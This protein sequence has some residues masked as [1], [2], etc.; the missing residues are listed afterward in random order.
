MARKVFSSKSSR[1]II[2][3][4]LLMV[5]L[6]FC[7]SHGDGIRKAFHDA[8]QRNV[9]L[10][11]RDLINYKVPS[12]DYSGLVSASSISRSGDV[13]IHAVFSPGGVKIGNMKI[14]WTKDDAFT[15]AVKAMEE[16]TAGCIAAD[17]QL[18]NLAS[19]K[20]DWTPAQR[21]CWDEAVAN[22]IAGIVHKE[23][24]LDK[25]RTETSGD[26]TQRTNYM[27]GL[28]R[29]IEGG[30]YKLEFDCEGM[31]VVKCVL[32][33]RMAERFL[34]A[35]QRTHYFYATGQ[36]EFGI[37][38]EAP[39][40]HAF[41]VL[42]RGG[43]VT[44]IIEGTENSDVYRRPARDTSFA[45]FATNKIFIAKDGSSYGFEYT[46]EQADKARLEVGIKPYKIFMQELKQKLQERKLRE[47]QGKLSS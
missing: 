13:P 41:I 45:D 2:L 36:G 18:L 21:D 35:H 20:T 14:D 6:M 38:D 31:S 24:G 4:G 43:K 12:G 15:H 22:T 16:K 37:Y 25:Y 30:T 28:S 9:P 29:D 8:S 32:Q 34:P 23:P 3:G 39:G 46:H 11:Q 33:H 1:N 10:E 27:N 26:G 42:E 44:G 19:L 5:P 17:P 7:F 47:Q 40:G